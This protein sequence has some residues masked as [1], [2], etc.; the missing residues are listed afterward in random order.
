MRRDYVEFVLTIQTMFPLAVLRHTM[1]LSSPTISTDMEQVGIGT[2]NNNLF[3][4]VYAPLVYDNDTG[5]LLIFHLHKAQFVDAW[6]IS[7]RS[8]ENWQFQ[9][10]LRAYAYDTYPDTQKFGNITRMDESALA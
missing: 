8:G 3:Y 9:V 10:L 5:D 6:E 7:M 2:I 4:H 1:K